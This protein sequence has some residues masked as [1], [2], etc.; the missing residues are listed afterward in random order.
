ME[1]SA[2]G[3]VTAANTIGTALFTCRNAETLSLAS[4]RITSGTSAANSAQTPALLSAILADGANNECGRSALLRVDP[5]EP[6]DLG[7]LLGFLDNELAEVG[8]RT[9]QCG[10]A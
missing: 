9:H 10:S 1:G 4:A 5:R 2:T 3:S 6:D 8:R 7:P